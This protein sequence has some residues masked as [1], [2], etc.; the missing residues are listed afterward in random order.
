[1]AKKG[2]IA[3]S[4]ILALFV[5]IVW[6]ATH[7]LAEN[8]NQAGS[9]KT[10]SDDLYTYMG[11]SS[12][13]G[14]AC[15]GNSSARDTLRIGQNEFYIWSQKDRHAK[16]YEVLTTAEAMLIAKNLKIAKPAE[17]GRCLACHAVAVHADHQGDFY[18]ITEGVSCE[19]CHGPA[20]KWLNPH[21]RPGFDPQNAAALGM[22]NMGDLVKRAEKCLECHAGSDGKEVTHEL[23]G[24]GHPRL[25]FEID[26][27]TAVMPPHWRPPKEKKNRDWL[28][29]RLWAIGQA[30][31]FRS[32]ITRVIASRRAGIGLWRD[33]TNFDCF[34]C[35][36]PV[37]DRL[38]GITEQDK[39]GQAWR[40][41]DYHGT[42]GRLVWNS[43]SYAVFRHVVNLIALEEGKQLEQLVRTF[44]EGL[45]GKDMPPTS[46]NTALTRLSA[47]SD[48]LVIQ[49]AQY[50]FTRQNVLLLM[51]NISGDG[52]GLTTSGFQAVEQAVL[53]L[54][55]LYDAYVET[56]GTMPEAQTIK[57]TID[58]LYKETQSGKDFN[59]SEF[60]ATL[61]KLHDRLSRI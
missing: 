24:A 33:F 23:I 29:T 36:H 38:R 60:E 20:E 34:A 21:I 32:Q 43:S 49:V 61:N 30:A 47:L 39:A 10:H 18:D 27:Y 50:T 28:G 2:L 16:A 42:P 45:T 11:A 31:A 46:F 26:N 7:P 44:H 37:I 59:A 17:S 53:A 55:S 48:K 1:V 58:A 3:I 15:H 52:P 25:M 35:H 40:R 56:A 41:R 54:S 57:D 13:S 51:Q 22:S 12:C 6:P 9:E 19:G 14:S 4:A 8:K 5:F